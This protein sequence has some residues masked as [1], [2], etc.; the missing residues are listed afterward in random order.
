[1]D[2]YRKNNITPLHKDPYDNFILQ[3]SGEKEWIVFSDEYDDIIYK[4]LL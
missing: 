4:T 3:L 1:M 2:K